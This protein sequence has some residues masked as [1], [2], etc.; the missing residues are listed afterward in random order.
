M[1]DL[2]PPSSNGVDL[3]YG[4]E[5]VANA[6]HGRVRRPHNIAERINLYSYLTNSPVN[7]VDPMGLYASPGYGH[8][9]GPR[10]G[11][12]WDG[13]SALD[14]LDHACKWHDECIGPLGQCAPFT[15]AITY[16]D[17]ELSIKAYYCAAIGCDTAACRFWAAVIGAWMAAP[18]AGTV[19]FR[20]PVLK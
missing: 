17:Q 9:C 6:M 19:P 5:Y 20:G 18:G 7:Y 1:I 3:L 12:E 2:D 15:F 13:V 4:H 16:C 8:F 11:E 14:C 10:N